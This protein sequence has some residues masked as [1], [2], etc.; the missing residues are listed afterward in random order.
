MTR[1]VYERCEPFCEEK[2]ACQHTS[3]CLADQ[4]S[5]ET[6]GHTTET[7]CQIC[8]NTLAKCT[9]FAGST[10]GNTK[11]A[12]ACQSEAFCI[13][14]VEKDIW[15]EAIEAA[16]IDIEPSDIGAGP[17]WMDGFRAGIRRYK[18]AIRALKRQ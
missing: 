2:G 9:C 6:S 14:D 16:E 8:K 7:I 12:Q 4:I 15:N 5:T 11:R 3:G 1:P 18:E 17:Y 13:A 10:T